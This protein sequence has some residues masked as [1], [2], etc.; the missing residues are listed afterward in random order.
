MM[1]LHD[2]IA[3][4][5][6]FTTEFKRSGTS[7]LGRELCAFANA[8]GGV[9]LIGVSDDGSVVGVSDP[10][11]LKSEVQSVA[12]A[13][14]PPLIVD[15][16]EINGVLAITIPIQ[17][18]KPYSHAGKFY[19]RD[20][21]SS[22]Q[23]TRDEI[24]AFF[25]K[26]GLIRF[27]EMH[28]DRFDMET[29]FTDARYERFARRAHL[30]LE[31][32]KFHALENLH[33]IRDGQ[34]TNAG[35]WLLGDDI[36]KFNTSAHVSCALFL[37]T[38]KTRILDRK[39]F[40]GD[41][42]SN[43]QDTVTYLLSKLSTELIIETMHRENRPELP[44][45]ALREAIV[46]ALAHRDYRSAANVQIYI[47]EDR[48]EIVSPGGLPAGMTPEMLGLKSFPRNP[49]LFGMLYRMD[50]VEQ[51]GSGIRRIREICK[52]Y[53][54]AEP[55]F[56]IDEHGVTLTLFRPRLKDGVRVDKPQVGEQVGEQVSE[57]VS[58]QVATILAACK[59]APRNKQDLLGAAGLSNAYMNYKRHLVPLLEQKLIEM[60]LPEKPNSRL[61]QYRLTA[62]GRAA[63][64]I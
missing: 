14:D 60:T 13:I 12:R 63:I 57:Q 51:V 23:M 39:D 42:Y 27:D 52:D 56:E 50:A 22:Q 45:A 4:G 1:K 20:G 48:V 30:P 64:N 5:E 34:M 10:N 43:Y 17:N 41:V 7:H 36:L 47:F 40:S 53:G 38:T 37:G 62:K 59:G 32:D 44:E 6:G 55:V 46:N 21:A 35:A 61:Q 58:E 28:C 26:E 8:N 49:L 31:L 19:F 18:S 15:V 9:V 25:F 29:D 11:R 33:L 2:I 3:L 24:R 54:I 16:E